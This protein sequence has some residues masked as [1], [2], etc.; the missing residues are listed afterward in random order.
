MFRLSK[1]LI[2]EI[3][4]ND[5]SRSTRTLRAMESRRRRRVVRDRRGFFAE[6]QRTQKIYTRRQVI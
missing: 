2:K 1:F 6:R 5:Q 3:L 4:K